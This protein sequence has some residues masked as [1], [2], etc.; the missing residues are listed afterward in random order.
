MYGPAL[1]GLEAK[2]HGLGIEP[3]E[4]RGETNGPRNGRPAGTGFTPYGLGT[5]CGLSSSPGLRY[6]G[7]IFNSL[8]P[9]AHIPG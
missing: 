9:Y 1:E 5:D 4:G 2:G 7:T 3:Y 6:Q 8:R